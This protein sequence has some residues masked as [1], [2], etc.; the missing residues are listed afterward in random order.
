MV[1]YAELHSHTNFS[2]L[3]GASHPADLVRRA[4]DLGYTALAVTDHHGLYGAARFR[5]AAAEVGLPTV[6]GVEIG[7]PQPG[8]ESPTPPHPRPHPEHGPRPPAPAAPGARRPRP[9]RHRGREPP[10]APQGADP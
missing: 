5:T 9:R 10:A 4:A 6:Y 7:L 2:F 3:D 8:A 1:R